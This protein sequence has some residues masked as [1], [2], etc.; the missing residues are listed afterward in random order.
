MATVTLGL[1]GHTSL[2][3]AES[4]IDWSTFDTLDTDIKKEG[5]NGITG[6]F[7]ADGTSGYY[8]PGSNGN[9]DYGNLSDI[10]P[11]AHHTPDCILS[12]DANSRPGLEEGEGPGGLQAPKERAYDKF[13]RLDKLRCLYILTDTGDRKAVVP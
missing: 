11:Q 8:D 13:C 5:D 3:T 4:T 7:R 12:E 1:L 10:L 9:L 6:T 2:S